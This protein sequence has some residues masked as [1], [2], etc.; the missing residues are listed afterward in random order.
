MKI[1]LSCPITDNPDYQNDLMLLEEKTKIAFPNAFI[2]NPL[3]FYKELKKANPIKYKDCEKPLDIPYIDYAQY[4][5]NRL[6]EC[7]LIIMQYKLSLDDY[8]TLGNI[9]LKIFH[10]LYRKGFAKMIINEAT[11]DLFLDLKQ[12]Y[13]YF[14]NNNIE[15]IKACIELDEKEYPCW[16]DMNRIF[17]EDINKDTIYLPMKRLICF[18]HYKEGRIRLCN[19]KC[20]KVHIKDDELQTCMFY[21]PNV[22]L[23]SADRLIAEAKKDAN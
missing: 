7:D 5:I 8:E 9:E 21:F 1:Y 22:K 15:P 20:P 19:T 2:V 16:I 18:E 17:I 14:I 12:H 11:L 13:D 3:D 23:S 4:S 10:R 6:F